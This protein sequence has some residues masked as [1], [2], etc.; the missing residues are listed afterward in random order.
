ME[1]AFLPKLRAT[2]GPAPCTV[3]RRRL[4]IVLAILAFAAG[5]GAIVPGLAADGAAGKV[6]RDARIVGDN[7]R[8]RLVIDLS[9]VAEV[10]VFS[11][12]DPY[13]LVVDLPDVQFALPP[14]AGLAGRGLIA[15]FRFGAIA[16]GKSRIVADL[17]G[18]VRIERAFVVPA[19][20]NEP[21]RV[22]V[23]LVPTGRSEF[24]GTIRE[25]R[26]R[27][28]PPAGQPPAQPKSSRPTVVIDAGHGGIDP[29]ARGT[30]QLLEKDVVLAF[31]HVLAERLQRSGRYEVFETRT[32]DSF[33]S[34]Q[35]RVDF[36]RARHADLLLS[37]H[38]NIAT[39]TGAGLVRGAAVFTLSEQAS[40]KAAAAMADVENRADILAG[41]DIAVDDRSDVRDILLDLTRR[42]TKNFAIQFAQAFVKA[43]GERARLSRAPHQQANFKVLGAPDIPSA[44]IELGYLSNSDDEK[45]LGSPEWRERTADAVA[46]AIDAFFGPR[47][48]RAGPVR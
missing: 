26:D 13:R 8:T 36:A 24:L 1:P 38:A 6:A 46:A 37:I 5:F 32:D 12:A 20:A 16:K 30:K 9:D 43:F 10:S 28:S 17:T 14:A 3:V 33:M 15:A 42:E 31:S 39:G 2:D 34:L 22:I 21:P 7:A 18:P 47:L 4:P 44:L 48:A 27:E 23:D 29:G 25:A 41:V 40:D 35:A 45:A 19:A 11:L